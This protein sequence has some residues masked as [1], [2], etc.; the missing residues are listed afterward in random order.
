MSAQVNNWDITMDFFKAN[1]VYLADPI[2][3]EVKTKYKKDYSNILWFIALT[4][5]P[6]SK[7]TNWSKYTKES[8]LNYLLPEKFLPKESEYLDFLSKRYLSLCETHT[9]RLL[10]VW[11]E[12]IDK[13]TKFL[14]EIEYDAQTYEMIE[15][16]LAGNL[17]S[18]KEWEEINKQLQKDKGA[19]MG[20]SQNSLSDDEVI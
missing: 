19:N 9:M 7:Y 6:D 2:F 20:G 11:K 15:K 5:D 14:E 17:K 12:T 16:M 3:K 1:P 13:K 10:R 8:E 18:Y 4:N